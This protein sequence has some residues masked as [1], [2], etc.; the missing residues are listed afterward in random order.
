MN[1]LSRTCFSKK[2]FCKNEI[3]SGQDPDPGKNR[4]ELFNT[5]NLLFLNK[6]FFKEISQKIFIIQTMKKKKKKTM[7]REL[8]AL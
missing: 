6:I 1:Q 8:I 4:P 3:Y 5:L 7:N 2:K